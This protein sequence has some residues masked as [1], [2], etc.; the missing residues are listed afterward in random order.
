MFERAAK[1][2]VNERSKDK[3]KSVLFFAAAFATAQAS[4]GLSPGKRRGL[5]ARGDGFGREKVRFC[6]IT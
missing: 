6:K 5:S 1:F 2:M 4:F 3:M